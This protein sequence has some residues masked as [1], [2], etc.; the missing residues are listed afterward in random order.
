MSGFWQNVLVRVG[1]SA[2][3]LWMMLVLALGHVWSAQVANAHAST[4]PVGN[5]IIANYL[6][7]VP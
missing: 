3:A 5:F 1:M 2:R 4:E 6:T 7:G